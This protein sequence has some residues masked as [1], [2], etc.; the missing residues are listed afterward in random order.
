MNKLEINIGLFGAIS[1]GKTTFLNAITGQQYSDTEI[2]KT[3]MVPQVY[4]E[5]DDIK[6]NAAIIRGKNREA[7]E[8]ILKLLDLNQFTLTH[9]QPIYHQLDRI[10]DMFDPEIIDPNLKINIYDIPGLNDSASKN[11]YFEW[12]RQNINLFDIIIFMTD[13]TKG[14][15][16]SDEIEII[17]LL[18][19][20][21]T[22]SKS[23]MICL[24]NKCDDIYY[25]DEINDLVFEE[26]QEEN[27]YIQANNIL[28]EIARKYN[29]LDLN[30]INSGKIYGNRITAFIPISSENC[31]VYRALLKN[32]GI[33]IELDQI[34]KNRICKNECG[35]SQWKRMSQQERDNMICNVIIDLEKTY[36]SKI[37]DTGYLSVKNIIQNTIMENKTEFL[38]YRLENEISKL[39]VPVLDDVH[40]YVT[41]VKIYNDKLTMINQ[42]RN[43]D[44]TVAYDALWINVKLTIN[45]YIN[46]IMKIDTR[47]IRFGDLID[48]NEFD[49]LH[50]TMQD[51][52]LNFY[53]LAKSLEELPEYPNESINQNK[54]RLSNKLLS[55]YD[56]LLAIEWVDQSHIKP[57]NLKSYLDI[58]AIYA[59]EKLSYYFTKFLELCVGSKCRNLCCYEKSLRNLITFYLKDR[60]ISEN[61]AKSLTLLL[62]NKIA[63]I[64]DKP[65]EESFE[66]LVRLKNIINS[67]RGVYVDPYTLIDIVYE[68]INKHISLALNANSIANIYRQEIDNMKIRSVVDKFTSNKAIDIDFETQLLKYINSATLL[69]AICDRWSG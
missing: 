27:I 68:V 51:Y 62:L 61:T 8:S 7:N 47:V 52:C 64:T 66:Y 21:M 23:R 57:D 33:D 17:D 1:S 9:C 32:P 12:V 56:Q 25:D 60:Q 36:Y 59:E 24:M 38:V 45:N 31:F 50:A 4:L 6:P 37:R 18:I 41:R 2:K 16:N 29:M 26:K 46:N 10:C 49:K 3:T 58:I 39:L 13:I 35:T 55:I 30:N 5:T 14:L 40:S 15:N 22:R 11:I 44:I 54:N 65:T 67:M 69:P 48:L 43:T 19:E 20:S 34:H 53:T 42:L 63:L 28:A